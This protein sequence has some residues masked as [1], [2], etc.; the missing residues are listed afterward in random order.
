MKRIILV[1]IF[2]GCGR[3]VARL[4]DVPL[5]PVEVL[6]DA[7]PVTTPAEDSGVTADAG[8]SAPEDAGTPPKSDAGTVRDAGECPERDKDN[9][10][11]DGDDHK[12]LCRTDFD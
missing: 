7:G 11:K 8:E 4:E 3:G 5:E 1:L 9:G 12:R 10:K 2:V 6:P